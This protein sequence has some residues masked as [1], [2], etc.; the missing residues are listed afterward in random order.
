M[1]WGLGNVPGKSRSRLRKYLAILIDFLYSGSRGFICYSKHAQSIYEILGKPTF[2]APNSCLPAPDIE[3]VRNVVSNLNVKYQ[4]PRLKILTIGELKKQK[5][6]DELIIGFSRLENCNIE[7]HIIGDGSE[8]INLELL[9]S[10][11][12]VADR[13]IFHGAIYNSERKKELISASSL[14]VL[15]G[16]GGLVIQ[17]LMNYGLPVISGLADGTEQDNIIHGVNGYLLCEGARSNEI[18]EAIDQF[19]VLSKEKK[20]EMAISAINCVLRQYNIESMVEGV[21]NAVNYA[22]RRSSTIL[23]HL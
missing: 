23:N 16:R 6:F 9:S 15:P 4:S 5:K 14:G 2:V 8:R 21:C 12:G 17:E 20:V 7:L 11:F 19:L 10:Q 18:F 22:T 13:V 1:V 3:H